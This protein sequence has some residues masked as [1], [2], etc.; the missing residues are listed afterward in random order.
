MLTKQLAF[1]VEFKEGGGWQGRVVFPEPTAQFHDL[2][3]AAKEMLHSAC[4]AETRRVSHMHLLAERLCR[5]DLRQLSLFPNVAPP[6]EARVAQ[7]KRDINDTLGRFLVRSGDT[8]AL[9]DIYDDEAQDFDICDIRG[10]L[11]F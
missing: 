2:A 7:V 6:A 11:C 1:A 5:R 10:K 4:R 9:K 3:A 8:L